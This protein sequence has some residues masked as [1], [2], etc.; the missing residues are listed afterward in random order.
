MDEL[1][2]TKRKS[3]AKTTAKTTGRR[4]GELV[5]QQ[6]GGALRNGGPNRGGPG[7]P[8]SALR[9]RLRGSF[10]ERV[11]IIEEIADGHP[12]VRTQIRLDAVLPYVVCAA[13][14][15]D[16][17]ARDRKA[18]DQIEIDAVTS[19]SPRDRLTALDLAA[20]YGLGSLKEISVDSVRERVRETLAVIRAQCPAAL[21]TQILAELRPIWSA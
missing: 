2:S 3:T 1:V 18:L 4:T 19:A 20:K 14:G 17:I 8:A 16:V 6:H 5:P 11:A 9:D 10:D 15:G 7:R 12:T 13:C 21:A